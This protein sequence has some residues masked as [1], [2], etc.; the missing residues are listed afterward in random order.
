[1][2]DTKALQAAALPTLVLIHGLFSSPLEFALTS[3]LLRS[4]GVRFDCLEIP[5]YTLADRGRPSSWRDWLHVASAALDARYEPQEAIVLCGLCVGGALAAALAA[6]ARQQRVCGVAMLSPTFDY[7]GWSLS[8]WRHLRR[9]GYA[10]GL[11]RWITVRE[12]E[13]FGIKNPKI[14]KWVVREF[15]R[16]DVSSIGPSR[17]PLWGLRESERLHAHVRPLLR[18][19]LR[20]LAMPLLVLHA[21]EDEITSLASV[22][23]WVAELGDRAWLVTLE[24]S[25][26]M[27]TIDNDRQRVAHELADFI[28]A[29]KTTRATP[30]PVA[31]RAKLDRR[32]PGIGTS[33]SQ[34]KRKCIR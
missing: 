34:G 28:G 22:A 23:A 4:R 19:L 5:G 13:P 12:R 31:P 15:E 21:R 33:T 9:L 29:P 2:H 10:L 7:D 25:Y 30:R 11:A 18:T 24:H 26:H 14:R 20:T 32:P 8:R 1:M 16:S 6:E 17:L 27:I 3:Q